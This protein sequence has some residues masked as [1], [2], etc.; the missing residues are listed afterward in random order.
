[1]STNTR[2]LVF[3]AGEFLTGITQLPPTTTTSKQ[4][5]DQILARRL[6]L[7]QSTL[8]ETQHYHESK[9]T[10]I[11]LQTAFLAT[12]ILSQIAAIPHHNSPASSTPPAHQAPTPPTY[13]A[14][15]T[16]V[17]ATLAGIV[18]RWGI[19]PSLPPGLLPPSVGATS[20]PGPS[21]PRTSGSMRIVELPP[22]SLVPTDKDK[23]SQL[24]SQLKT[25]LAPILRIVLLG[26]DVAK[27]SP[28]FQLATCVLPEI[29]LPLF[30]GM[31]WIKYG[32]AVNGDKLARN[33]PGSD[34]NAGETDGLE[35]LIKMNT[36]INVLKT[37]LTLHASSSLAHPTLRSTLA[38]LLSQQL[39]RPGGVRSLIVLVIGA[40]E[41]G[42][43]GGS[44][45]GQK[46]DMLARLLAKT[47][48]GME[49][50]E[51][52]ASIFPQLMQVIQSA[53]NS[54]LPASTFK[55]SQ[56]RPPPPPEGITTSAAFVMCTL[57][58][59]YP[60]LA[61]NHILKPFIL[62]S[63][64]VSISPSAST[65]TATA[66]SNFLLTPSQL[67]SRLLFLSTLLS[68]APPLPT[69]LPLLVS[70]ILPMLVSLL[71]FLSPS[72]PNTTIFSLPLEKDERLRDES[73]ALILLWGKGVT[74]G[75]VV[76]KGIL[77]AVKKCESS[78][79]PGK[80]EFLFDHEGDLGVSEEG[81]VAGWMRDF[82]SDGAIG[83]V[84][85]SVQHYASETQKAEGR[86]EAGLGLELN[87]DAD[88]V[89]SLLKELGRK[90]VSSKIFLRWVDEVAVL[91]MSLKDMARERSIGL[92]T[93][94]GE[95]LG[96]RLLLRL[97]LALK[98][99]EEIGPSEL[100]HD[101]IQVLG[102]VAHALDA[103][104]EAGQS[105]SR[106]GHGVGTGSK[107]KRD[108]GGLGLG[109]LKIV[110]EEELDEIEEVIAEDDE[111][112]DSETGLGKD[113]MTVTALTLLLAVL[114]GNEELSAANTNLLAVIVPRLDVLKTSVTSP[115]IA[116][117]A[118]EARMVLTLR[119]ASDLVSSS[120]SSDKESDPLAASRST[121][122]QA[123]KLLQDPILPL[124]AQ[125]LAMLRSLALAP[126]SETDQALVPAILEVF[127]SA[128]EEDDSFL[129]LNAV[130]GLTALVDT[131]GRR[132]VKRLLEVY[133]GRDEARTGLKNVLGKGEGGIREMDKRLRIAEALVGCVQ[134]AGEALAL[135]VEELVSPLVAILRATDLPTPFRASALTI[136]AT[137]VESGP[138]AML[139]AA[140]TIAEACLTLLSVESVPLKP[141]TPSLKGTTIQSSSKPLIVE[142]DSD[143]DEETEQPALDKNG[144]PKVP[145]E[146]P[147]PGSS[148]AKSQ[149]SLRRAALLFLGL[150]FRTSRRLQE[151]RYESSSSSALPGGLG[152]TIRMPGSRGWE[153]VGIS[154]R[155]RSNTGSNLVGIET[156]RRARTVLGY[157]QQTDEDGL[158]RF[159]AGEVLEELE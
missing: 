147:D 61:Q 122:Q 120:N 88:V 34:G 80:G 25:F 105:A 22:D 86:N 104:Q 43:G 130:G 100:V 1:M 4:T 156:R 136:L 123:L 58:A 29:L 54:T 119:E 116:P 142:V 148:D 27:D 133:Y 3:Q 155:S 99:V 2:K 153:S 44:V 5:L 67:L 149:P 125:G 93:G 8:N 14:R 7:A 41:D 159:Q 45:P 26:K 117:L 129:Y 46:L 15:D 81:R 53:A 134:R 79:K 101:P 151:D 57:L 127:V 63:A 157:I 32:G 9:F 65:S 132:V 16:K 98:M 77:E 113:E 49:I 158:V 47:P 13:G 111:G 62:P 78:G 106:N 140:D 59:Q 115:L 70:P 19:A 121:Y 56:P 97:Q 17:I 103:H 11:Q 128:V 135:F 55:A 21:I 24:D 40:G 87:L 118:R 143:D 33:E 108:Q 71:S 85:I 38:D 131:Y 96:A 90:D 94:N 146:T 52:H 20:S 126:P 83:E 109:D 31:V 150:L 95:E 12:H 144:K 36:P 124:R 145:E 10:S 23:Q 107:R 60:L 66:T 141:K 112:G 73:V 35:R 139:P 92:G 28:A 89:V 110:D 75:E 6:Q 64:G 30:A 37:L 114:E 102:F 42:A 68:Y 18:G 48:S 82:H 154:I 51:Y 39:F 91:R 50:E 69:N 74:E 138:K 84:G 76:V 152:A 137:M 72:K